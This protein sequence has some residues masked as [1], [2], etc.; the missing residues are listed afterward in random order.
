MRWP[1]NRKKAAPSTEQESGRPAAKPADD[2]SE[3][4]YY[5]HRIHPGF[6]VNNVQVTFELATEDG[7]PVQ[8]TFV[9][10]AKTKVFIPDATLQM[11]VSAYNKE[12][13]NEAAEAKKQADAEQGCHHGE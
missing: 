1:W 2:S 9:V 11:M 3:G 12:L 13:M 6:L 4:Y 5:P 8:H 10:P 7:I